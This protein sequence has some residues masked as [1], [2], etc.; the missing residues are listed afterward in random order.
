M[1]ILLFNEFMQ[2]ITTES[3]NI[4]T[5]LYHWGDYHLVGSGF[6]PNLFRISFYILLY[7]YV[8]DRFDSLKI[9]ISIDWNDYVKDRFYN[10]TI[11]L[12]IL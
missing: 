1:E 5:E 4:F 8:K 3:L 7:Q 10:F 6:S 2:F 11:L 9:S 12:V